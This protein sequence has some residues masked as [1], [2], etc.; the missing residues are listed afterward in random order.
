A[1][2]GGRRVALDQALLAEPQ[3]FG[4]DGVGG[5]GPASGGLG[6]GGAAA[7][8]EPHGVLVVAGH[9][10]AEQV[11]L[12]G[13]PEAPGGGGEQVVRQV[14]GVEQGGPGAGLG[15][16]VGQCRSEEHTSEL[17]SRENLVCRRLL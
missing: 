4:V 16:L 15:V 11:G 10:R 13:L 2:Q 6:D 17:Q 14:V 12:F 8:G 1:A 5:E 3:V 9:V 7:G